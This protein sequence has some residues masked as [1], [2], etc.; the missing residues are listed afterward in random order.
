MLRNYFKITVR[1]LIKKKIFSLINILGL[2]LGLMCSILILLWVKHELSFDQFHKN[3]NRIYRVLQEMPFT[4]KTTWAITQGPLAPALVEEIPEIEYATRIASGPWNIKYG[5]DRFQQSAIYIDKSFFNIFDFKLLRGDPENALI[6][7]NSVILTQKTARKLFG[8]EDP[9]GKY[10]KLFDLLDV[11]VTGLLEAP[12]QNSHLQF[13]MLGSLDLANQLGYTVDKWNNSGFVTY[14]LSREDASFDIINSKIRNILD[15]KPTLENNSKLY[16]Q[17]L[18][19]I[20]LSSDIDFETANIGNKKYVIIFFGSA[21]FILFVACINFMNLS[22]VQATQRAREVGLRKAIG[23]SRNQLLQQ[24]LLESI[25][26][27]FVAFLVAI[28]MTELFLPTFNDFTGKDLHLHYFS[29]SNL[30]LII[31]LLLLTSL[32]SGSYPAFVLAS[33]QPIKV[34]KG[35][36]DKKTRGTGFKKILVVFQYAISMILLIGTLAVY[37]QI[38]FMKNKNQGY[39]KENL[40]Y[41][42]INNDIRQHLNTFKSVLLEHKDIVNVAGSIVSSGFL[43][44]NN[45]WAWP[46]KGPKTDILF[47]VSPVDFDYIETFEM[48]IVAGRAFSKEFA[49]DSKSVILNET[50][51]KAMGLE[52]PVGSI[53]TSSESGIHHEIIGIVKDYNFRS[54]HAEIEPLILLRE[55]D[56]LNFLWIRINSQNINETIE[57]MQSKWQEFSPSYQFKYE[58]MSQRAQLMYETEMQIGKVLQ[59]F[60]AIALAVLF[61]GLSGLLGFS[62]RQRYK[63]ISI[64]RVLGASTSAILFVLSIDYIRLMLIAIIFAIPVANYL[65]KLWLEG[66]AFRTEIGVIVYIIPSVTLFTVASI[67]IIFQSLRA[68][69]VD[70]SNVLRNE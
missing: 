41:L 45:Q 6:N 10:L 57:F 14:I 38:N 18:A 20:H 37:T 11:Q 17:S 65:I 68:T 70:V 31:S 13:D 51:I 60:S 58:F 56:N 69:N 52:N 33:F 49:S 24:F 47:R 63:E 44:S 30:F 1:N 15:D 5:N 22:T 66:F 27:I 12:P 61:L 40:I 32:L 2:S 64:R 28:V 54:L 55:S 43:Y 48:E 50:A 53:L 23:A 19:D 7:P 46:G 39:N 34:L 3:H 62:L 67:V 16:I 26:L 29:L 36:A 42:E 59:V 25:I 9:I 21:L 35:N 4:E 8:D